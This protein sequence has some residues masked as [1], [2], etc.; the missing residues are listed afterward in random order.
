MV[1]ATVV[2]V[3]IGLL[4]F[5]FITYT[6]FSDNAI[7]FYNALNVPDKELHVYPELYHEIL[8][9]TT[10]QQIFDCIRSWAFEMAQKRP[11]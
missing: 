9:E 11:N 1:V 4:T 10:R 6:R 8:N 2:S 5:V 7:D 3:E